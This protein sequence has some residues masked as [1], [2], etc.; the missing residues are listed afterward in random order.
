MEDVDRVVVV[1]LEEAFQDSTAHVLIILFLGLLHYLVEGVDL[2][3]SRE[4]SAEHRVAFGASGEVGKALVDH[5]GLHIFFC[6]FEAR[7]SPVGGFR[8]DS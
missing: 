4:E 2:L 5:I 7:N 8:G 6:V 1:E 3:L